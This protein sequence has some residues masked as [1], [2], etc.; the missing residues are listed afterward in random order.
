MRQC[1]R[2]CEPFPRAHTHSLPV[3]AA[4]RRSALSSPKALHTRTV[5]DARAKPFAHFLL[6]RHL[7]TSFAPRLEEREKRVEPKWKGCSMQARIEPS[8]P[9]RPLPRRLFRSGTGTQYCTL[10]TR[11][12]DAGEVV[13]GLSR[14]DQL[15][16]L[17]PP[18]SVI[19]MRGSVSS[20]SV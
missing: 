1:T 10:E 14:L 5:Q 18:D 8:V 11:G 2:R 3:N 19:A 6:P 20:V 16:F 12:R 4:A 17:W 15:R 13:I 7:P 9:S